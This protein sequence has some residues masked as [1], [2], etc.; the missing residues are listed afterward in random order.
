MPLALSGEALMQTLHAFFTRWSE[1]VLP[2]HPHLYLPWFPLSHRPSPLTSINFWPYTNTAGH[3][4]WYISTTEEILHY[5]AISEATRARTLADPAISARPTFSTLRDPV[6][7]IVDGKACP[8]LYP[9]SPQA[10]AQ[11][12]DTNSDPL[13]PSRRLIIR[14]LDGRLQMLKFRMLGSLTT[15]SASPP[16]TRLPQPAN[17]AA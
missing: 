5:D 12:V 6:G 3:F 13:P 1:G 15:S 11:W 14:L 9:S 16:S 2:T 8:L 17:G 4:D 7:S 10:E